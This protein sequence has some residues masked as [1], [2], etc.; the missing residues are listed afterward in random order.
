MVTG[1]DAYVQSEKSPPLPTSKF[2]KNVLN[3]FVIN[4]VYLGQR[5]FWTKEW[6]E[7]E[8]EAND[9]IKHGRVKNF[10]NARNAIKYL[11]SRRK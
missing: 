7:G 1:T 2:A 5:Y 3:T 6:Q 10:M 8:K 11:R 4:D 9:D